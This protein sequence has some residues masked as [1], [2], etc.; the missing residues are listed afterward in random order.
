MIRRLRLV[1]PYYTSFK[2]PF[3]LNKIIIMNTDSRNR[4]KY[5]NI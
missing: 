4:F 3:N 5:E 2:I 1:A